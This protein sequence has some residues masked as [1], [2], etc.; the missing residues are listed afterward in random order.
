MVNG[1]VNDGIGY[2]QWLHNGWLFPNALNWT[3]G[4]NKAQNGDA[5]GHPLLSVVN[6]RNRLA[7]TCRGD[8]KQN[9]PAG[10]QPGSMLA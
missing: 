7:E 5:K 8:S 10:E 9:G 3:G 6:T 2:C 1:P 4:Q